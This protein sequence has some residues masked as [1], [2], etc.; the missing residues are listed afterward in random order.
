MIISDLNYL[1]NT[2]AANL[3]GGTTAIAYSS[4]GGAGFLVR[5]RTSASTSSS[6]SF[7]GKSSSAY[8]SGKASAVVGIVS[9]KSIAGSTTAF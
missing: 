9:S 5:A 7:F 4:A 3:Q 1:E 8:T 2:S 6:V